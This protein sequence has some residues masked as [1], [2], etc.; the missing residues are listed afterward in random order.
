MGPKPLSVVI[1]HNRVLSDPEELSEILTHELVH[2]YDVQSSRLDL[3]QCENLAYS[4]IR[5]AK[6]AEC[7]NTWNQLQTFCV[8]QKAICATKN[9]F[10]SR[11]RNCVHKVFARAFADSQPFK[12]DDR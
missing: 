2:L 4:E 9:L 5:A 10:P 3:Q 11:G 1:C 6:A 12:D 8:K 7:R